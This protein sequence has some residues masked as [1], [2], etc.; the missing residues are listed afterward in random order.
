MK[1]GKASLRPKR[2]QARRGDGFLSDLVRTN[3]GVVSSRVF[4]DPEINRFEMERIFTLSWLYVAQ[5]SETPQAGDFVTRSMG[6]DDRVVRA[7]REDEGI[8][9]CLPTPGGGIELEAGSGQFCR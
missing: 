2:K 4:S 7:G 8:F 5:E 9:K 3:E 6:D 1:K